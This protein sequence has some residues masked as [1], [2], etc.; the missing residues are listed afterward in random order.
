MVQASDEDQRN[1]LDAELARLSPSDQAVIEIVDDPRVRMWMMRLL[2]VA[3]EREKIY[4][5]TLP[6]VTPEQIQQNLAAAKRLV[7]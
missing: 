4:G 2:R 1:K 5:F 7:L 3:H 6:T